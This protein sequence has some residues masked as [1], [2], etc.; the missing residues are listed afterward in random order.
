MGRKGIVALSLTKGRKHNIIASKDE[1]L[2]SLEEEHLSTVRR[3][4]LYA[5]TERNGPFLSSAA[6]WMENLST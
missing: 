6:T 3:M 1:S 4:W 5:T 2:K